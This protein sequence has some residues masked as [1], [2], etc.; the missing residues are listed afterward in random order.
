[1][2]SVALG[3]SLCPDVC[4]PFGRSRERAKEESKWLVRRGRTQ[5]L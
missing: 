1:M 5:G 2:R 3:I 4:E